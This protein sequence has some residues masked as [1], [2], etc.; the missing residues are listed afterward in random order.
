MGK[1][2]TCADVIIDLH[3]RGFTHD[4]ALLGNKIW[5]IQ[6]NCFLPL[7]DLTILECH[8]I[9][10]HW[11]DNQPS[12]IFGLVVNCYDVK[13]I[14]I[15]HGSVAGRRRLTQQTADPLIQFCELKGLGHVLIHA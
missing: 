1:I 3:E 4:F 14:L 13:G 5:W 2:S 15:D 12:Y 11:E 10:G 9:A 8:D 6:E 7:A